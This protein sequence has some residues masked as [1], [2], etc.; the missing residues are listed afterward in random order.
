MRAAACLVVLSLALSAAGQEPPGPKEDHRQRESEKPASAAPPEAAIEEIRVKADSQGGTPEHSWARGFVDVRLGDARVQ[1]DAMDFY[2]ST[3]ADGSVE[4]KAV[5][6]GNVVFM[7]EEERISGERLTFDVDTGRGVFERASGYVQPGVQVEADTIERVDADTY[8]VTGARFTSCMQPNPRWSFSLSSAR[9]EVDDKVVGKNAVFRVKSVPA[10]YVPYF[11][12]PIG[13]DQ[14]STG[15]LFPHFG[16]SSLRGFNV[17]AGFFW[18]MGRSHDQTF[19]AD[20]YSR[21]G[22]GFGH[23]FRYDHGSPSAGYFTSYAFQPDGGGERDYDLVWRAS[24][25]LPWRFR[26]T[27]N[28]R[29]YS[30]IL[31]QEQ[32]QDSLNRASSRSENVQFAVQ[33]N[34]PLA[35]VQVLA[36]SRR[37]FFS[38]Q[39]RINRRLPSA[40][41]SRPQRKLG[42]T[43]LALGFDFRAE[44]LERGNE[45]RLDDYARYMADLDLGYTM[46]TTFLQVT[47]RLGLNYTHY[48]RSRIR[49]RVI[50][51]ELDRRY[52]EGAF[53]IQGP[54]FSRVFLNPSGVYSDKFKHVI[55]PEITWRYRTAID[56]FESVPK[57]DG[58][59]Q[60]LG[61]HQI[62]YAIVQRILAKR[63]GFGGKPQPW[64]FLSWRVGQTY[65]VQ[66]RDA[67]NEFDPNYSSSAFGPGGVPDHNSAIQ[68]RLRIRPGQ[69]TQ[70]TFDLEY[71][72]NFKQLRTISLGGQVRADRGTLLGNWSRGLTLA[73]EPAEREVTRD[74]L[75]VYASFDLLPGRLLLEGGVDW[76]IALKQVLQSRG[77]LRYDVQ[78]CGF[79]IEAIHY[80]F[81]TRQDNSIRF[82]IELANIGSIGNFLGGDQYGAGG[83][84]IGSRLR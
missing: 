43:D 23:E 20:H 25:L 77:G 40:R 42:S 65:Y 80:D 57:F 29:R 45:D 16:Y 63:P 2:R 52:L 84:V 72:V 37:T 70:A 56:D 83:G 66:I 21:F 35:N 3:R 79:T 30:D 7:R 4:Q 51:P 41:V 58:L 28:V 5:F 34:F 81:N 46:A 10:L 22:Y 69:N 9:I 53:E 19:Y 31:F 78:C 33:R 39:T 64:E 47:P 82:S 17:G 24:Q 15:F 76:D 68:S 18:A 36:E 59:D 73:L 54:N 62:D 12:Y 48:T 75:R 49:N 38:E 55:G 67:Q 8:R 14:R 27:V 13:E 60:Q 71:D 50:G 6:V 26:G 1:A 44:G 74:F 32:F 11:V 61:T